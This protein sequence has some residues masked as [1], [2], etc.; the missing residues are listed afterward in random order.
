MVGLGILNPIYENNFV[1]SLLHFTRMPNKTAK[2]REKRPFVSC[3][4]I[5]IVL[6]ILIN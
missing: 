6:Q 3:Q 4:N 2:L 1:S 5:I